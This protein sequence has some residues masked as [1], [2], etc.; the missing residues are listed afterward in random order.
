MPPRR[1]L[2][3]E[4]PSITI[5][6]YIYPDASWLQMLWDVPALHPWLAAALLMAAG[7]PLH[8]EYGWQ[9]VAGV[10]SLALVWA[11]KSGKLAPASFTCADAFTALRYVGAYGVA[12]L[13]WS[14]AAL[15]IN[16][17]RRHLPAHLLKAIFACTDAKC[18][19]ATLA[20]LRDTIFT[21]IIF[22]PMSIL[23]FLARDPLHLLY[24]LVWTQFRDVYASILTTAIAHATV[25]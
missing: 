24:D 15:Y 17:Y 23:M 11:A 3:Q 10:V 19:L 1:I 14:C 21:Y 2:E 7:A 6:P 20:L 18:T 4:D 5:Q 25:K 8:E 16:V 13:V 12:G 9:V 22:W